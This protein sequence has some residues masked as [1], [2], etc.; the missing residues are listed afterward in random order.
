MVDWGMGRSS[1]SR[2]PSASSLGE[3]NAVHANRAKP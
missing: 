2:N 1:R 3:G